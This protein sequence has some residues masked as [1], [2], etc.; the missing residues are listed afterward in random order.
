[1][2]DYEVTKGANSIEYI[3]CKPFSELKRHPMDKETMELLI[4]LMLIKDEIKIPEEKKPFILKVIEGSLQSRF[5]F[6]INDMKLKLFLSHITRSPG[7]AIM[8][9]TYLQYRCKIQSVIEIN[10]ET[11]CEKIFGD[12]LPND[13]DLHKLW[14]SQKVKR[15]KTDHGS[16][17]LLDYQSAF[18][19]LQFMEE[20]YKK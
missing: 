12:G 16:D 17:N 19:S 3:F 20:V 7:C 9:L 8:Y 14:E 1:M 4:H 13:E 5:T 18:K 11:F 15:S 6:K 10:L 2:L